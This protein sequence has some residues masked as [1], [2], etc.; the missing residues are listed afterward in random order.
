MTTRSIRS[1]AS[2]P[3]LLGLGITEKPTKGKT[4]KTPEHAPEGKDPDGPTRG[5]GGGEGGDGAEP[6][7]ATLTSTTPAF[8]PLRLPSDL[9]DSIASYSRLDGLYSLRGCC[10]VLRSVGN[11]AMVPD[12]TVAHARQALS[13]AHDWSP[14]QSHQE[15]GQR[16]VW[17]Q[18]ASS[19]T[20]ERMRRVA[21]DEVLRRSWRYANQN[22]EEVDDSDDDSEPPCHLAQLCF[23]LKMKISDVQAIL[24]L[25]RRWYNNDSYNLSYVHKT[26]PHRTEGQPHL[27]SQDVAE[28]PHP[29]R[30]YS[31]FNT[32]ADYRQFWS[33]P[34]EETT[35]DSG[36]GAKAC[37]G[38][39]MKYHMPEALVDLLARTKGEGVELIMTGYG[40]ESGGDVVIGVAL[41]GLEGAMPNGVLDVKQLGDSK[42]YA[43]SVFEIV[44]VSSTFVAEAV[45]CANTGGLWPTAQNA[46]HVTILH[47]ALHKRVMRVLQGTSLAYDEDDL[48]FFLAFNG[49]C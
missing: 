22:D 18:D 29:R 46:K 15:Q 21:A 7:T 47:D 24:Y 41:G 20:W 34:A 49:N 43:D 40:D 27:A 6:T 23:G 42:F 5:D 28:D 13:G 26:H 17:P 30:G 19:S 16:V 10:N 2:G 32:M 9:C 4:A 44:P 48:S 36:S 35:S 37:N 33:S 45:P 1:A 11:E 3:A 14:R 38:P 25:G 31:E 12:L 39:W 8:F